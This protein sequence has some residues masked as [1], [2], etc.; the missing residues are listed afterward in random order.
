MYLTCVN[1]YGYISI[2]HRSICVGNLMKK[3]FILA[4]VAIIFLG[5]GLGVSHSVIVPQAQAQACTAPATPVDV[6]VD[7]PGGT[8]TTRDLTLANCSWTAQSDAASY[9]ITVTEVETGTIIKNNEAVA[10]STTTVSFPI[11][12]QRT[13]KC[14]VTAVASCGTVSAVASDQLLCDADAIIDTP[15]PTTAAEVPPKAATPTIAAPGGIFETIGILGGV[16]L[17][18]ITGIVLLVL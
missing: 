18:V 3:S 13:Y 14:D 1:I 2:N 8:G 10:A 15:T 17:A 5:I 4:I 12:Q 7:Y 16:T 9:N 6:A 11:T